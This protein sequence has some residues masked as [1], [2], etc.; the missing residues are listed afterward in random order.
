MLNRLEAVLRI[1]QNR[2][3]GF[4]LFEVA[5]AA[6][7]LI[8]M[9]T[10]ILLSINSLQ[11][12]CYR[13]QVRLAAEMLAADIQSLQQE[14]MFSSEKFTKTLNVSNNDKLG[15]RIYTNGINSPLHKRIIFADC[16]YANVYFSQYLSSISFYKNGSPKTNG[17]YLLRHKKLENFYCKLSLQ[18]VTGRVTVTEYGS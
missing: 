16:G 11:R 10:A 1:S 2:Q 17:T 6:I 15:Y 7:F 9:S 5:L 14:T 18:P 12:Y 13:N 8:S 3:K 4:I